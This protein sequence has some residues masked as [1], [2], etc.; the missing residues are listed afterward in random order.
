MLRSW[1]KRLVARL[2]CK[3]PAR[4]PRRLY[5]P[6]A[7]TLESRLL[8][9]AGDVF[10]ADAT[11]THSGLQDKLYTSNAGLVGIQLNLGNNTYGPIEHLQELSDEATRT[12]QDVRIHSVTTTDDNNDGN[13]D[14]TVSYTD[15]TG[16][17]STDIFLGAG[18]GTFF[19]E[20]HSGSGQGGGIYANVQSITPAVGPAAGGTN[21]TIAGTLDWTTG[22]AVNLT[23]GGVLATPIAPATTNSS[24]VV[25][26]PAGGGAN[27]PLVLSVGA[28]DYR[29]NSTFSYD[30]PAITSLSTNSGP[31]GGGT[32]ITITGTSFSP[33][34]GLDTV[35]IGGLVAPIQSVSLDGTQL[36]VQT[37]VGDGTNLPVLVTV[38]GQAS[39]SA[40]FSYAAPTVTSISP[41]HGPATGGTPITIFGSSFGASPAVTIGGI[42]AAFLSVNVNETQLVVAVPA[43][44]GAGLDVVV[45]DSVTKQSASL[46][47]AFSYDA[48]VI[49]TLSTNSGPTGG[50]TVITITGTNFS[51]TLTLDTVTIGGFAAPIQSVSLDGT[52]LVVQTPVGDGTNLPVLVTVAGQASNAASF[53]YAAP[54][55]TSIS[56]A[57]GPAAG[58]TT[59]TI[60]GSSF[61]AS[62]AVTIG[63]INAAF[64]SVNANET[65]LVVAVPAGAGAGLDV[66]VT[67]SITKQSASLTKAFSYDAPVIKT[68][69]TNS[70][71]TG[72][73]TVITITGTSFSPNLGLD[74]V[75]IGGL[76]APIQSVSL[77]GTQL[78]VQTPVGDGTNLPVV[79]TVA[80]QASNS[81]SFSY[82][83]P[84]LTSISPAHG[85]AAGGTPITIFGS[86]FGASPTVTIGGINA[87]F[88]SV[89]ANETQLLVAA[90]AGAGTGLDVVVTDSITKQSA[91]LAKAFSYDAPVITSLL[92]SSGPTSGGT[93]ATITGTSFSPNLALDNV[94]IGGVPATLVS[95]NSSGT[96]LVIQTPAGQGSVPVVVTVGNQSSAASPVA[97]FAYNMPTI[98]SV[99]PDDGSAAGGKHITIFGNN[100][101]SNPTVTIGGVNATVL[102]ANSTKVVV[103][104]PPGVGTNLPVVLTT[105]GVVSNSFSFSY[106]PP[107]I[108][109]LSVND[110]LASGGTLVTI[111]GTSFSPTLALDGVTIGGLPA[112][113]VS[114]NS[115][116]T[117]LVILTPAGQGSAPVVVTVG[118]QSS[119]VSPAAVFTYDLPT[120]ASVSPDDGSA[121]GGKHI[122]ILGTSFGTNPTVTIGGVNA[123]VVSASN[124]K[125]V[126]IDPPGV[127]SNLPVVLTTSG[128]VSNSFSF[129]YD[130]PTISSVKPGRAPATNSP[131]ITIT[132]SSFSPTLAFDSVTI[133]GVTA[134]VVSVNSNGTQLVVQ[135]PPGKGIN[136]PVV[137]TVGTQASAASAA[138]V[139]S[140]D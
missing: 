131:L 122:T 129:S 79:V 56:P 112:T 45:T 14:L 102:S 86:S 38:A 41:A 19:F 28:E 133:G 92:P 58:G 66:V 15:F 123:T 101:G 73:G 17:L 24:A 69:S 50:G 124:N 63:G 34:L 57:H 40:S 31:T 27:L 93:L 130:P 104:D 16:V 135:L 100:F 55:L 52:Q 1:F 47:K 8:L 84:T 140:Y 30:A 32:V 74:T 106:D 36:V 115:N 109:A 51:P 37:P 46:A 21:I 68:L 9:S 139:F 127:G 97:V 29:L 13:P 75:T 6:N 43:G 18:D 11:L 96:K 12:Y 87:A 94:T 138:A 22:D 98:T 5:A 60:F 42:N 7:M 35:T 49:K 103:I 126:V 118:N 26:T 62:P 134:T 2:F 125:V 132:G 120:I 88:L 67:D 90:P 83:A 121:A 119:A 25:Q 80:G 107:A 70:G 111:T 137:V 128:L 105:S 61:G 113:L 78:V 64:L 53:S 89:N 44:A 82:A 3:S 114:V 91:S 99:S 39:N 108:T 10:Y 117:K 81:T 72:G 48:P 95:V 116:G 136:L 33:N 4:R 65:Q 20:S 110:G 77:D 54:T 76:V 71:P 59:I 23:I 85:P